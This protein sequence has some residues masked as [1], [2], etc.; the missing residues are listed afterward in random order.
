MTKDAGHYT[1]VPQGPQQW[2]EHSACFGLDPTLFD[3]SDF[4]QGRAVQ[5]ARVCA[6]CPVRN[7]HSELVTKFTGDCESYHDGEQKA[8]QPLHTVA[9]GYVYSR[10]SKRPVDAAEWPSCANTACGAPVRLAGDPREQ[11]KFCSYACLVYVR[12]AG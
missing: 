11:R 9:A 10:R 4:Q 5:A 7:K 8:R 2:R 12:R 1:Y 6:T 3:Y